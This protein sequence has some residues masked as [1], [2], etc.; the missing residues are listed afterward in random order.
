MSTERDVIWAAWL[1]FVGAGGIAV[2]SFGT[3]AGGA[4]TMTAPYSLTVLLPY[5]DGWGTTAYLLWPLVF[6][7]WSIQL[8]AR[9]PRIPLR[10]AALG[11]VA[12]LCS[13]AWI[14]VHWEAG[15][16]HQGVRHVVVIAA[17]NLIAAGALGWFM[18]RSRYR[19]T[20]A[21]SYAFHWLLFAWTAW[22]AL[23][24]FGEGI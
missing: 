15:V 23:P 3:A 2:V 8:F 6:L 1:M 20:F 11:G 14:C 9:V 4:P 5:M 24:W 12:V 21:T 18:L 22:S 16:T 17:L 19:P 13:A 7:L 10:S